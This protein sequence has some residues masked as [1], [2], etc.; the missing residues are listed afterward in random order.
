VAVLV[1][2]SATTCGLPWAKAV[3]A[4]ASSATAIIPVSNSNNFFNLSSFLD[5]LL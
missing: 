5:D 3:G 1:V 2:A 4:A